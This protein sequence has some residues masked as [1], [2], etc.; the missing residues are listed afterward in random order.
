MRDSISVAP[1][2]PNKINSVRVAVLVAT[3]TPAMAAPTHRLLGCSPSPIS[4]STPNSFADFDATAKTRIGCVWRKVHLGSTSKRWKS[5]RSRSP[6]ATLGTPPCCPI[7]WP[8][9][10]LIRTSPTHGAVASIPS[11][12]KA[13]P[14]KTVTAGAVARTEALRASK[15]IGRALWRRW[16]GDHR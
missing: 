1:F 4:A 13:K 15:Y 2:V 3:Q 7:C 8:R 6:A 12:K 16:S 14:W 10:P 11:C 5:G 9:S